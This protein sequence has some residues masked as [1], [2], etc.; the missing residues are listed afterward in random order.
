LETDS[1]AAPV[2]ST[3]DGSTVA[4]AD[5]STGDGS[6][7]MVQAWAR[8]RRGGL[9]LH[10]RMGATATVRRGCNDGGQRRG[11]DDDDAGAGDCA[12]VTSLPPEL[13][14]KQP[15]FFFVSGSRMEK[16]GA[17]RAFI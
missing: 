17:V 7:A 15:S 4:A 16:A 13:D 1:T 3:G 8:R 9:H 14:W 2:F 5:F 12:G 11:R 10:G 6:M